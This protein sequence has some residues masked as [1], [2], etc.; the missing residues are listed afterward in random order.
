VGLQA[1]E[2]IVAYLRKGLLRSSPFLLACSVALAGP[3]DAGTR[4]VVLHARDGGLT[5]IG[6]VTFSPRPDGRVAFSWQVDT[7]PFTDHFLSMREFKCLPGQ[8][9]ILCLVPYPYPH[10]GHVAR[11]DLAWLEH[12]LLFMYKKSSEFGAQLWNG[13]YFRLAVDGN[14]LV[15]TPQ[16]VDLNRISA[17][18][19]RTEVPPF[20]TAHRDDIPPGAR[21]YGRLTIE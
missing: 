13:V 15:G 4:R 3:L 6:A 8:G 7:A 9:E 1:D 5:V 12:S 17:P 14:R 20:G 10:P 2:V 19:Q 11:D 16:A 21:W 18:P